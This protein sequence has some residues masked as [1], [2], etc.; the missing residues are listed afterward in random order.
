[1]PIVSVDLGLPFA[2]AA[3]EEIFCVGDVHG[4]AKELDELLDLAASI[5]QVPGRRR[6]IVFNGDL[7]DRGPKSLCA[8]D[9]AISAK[10]RI[11]ADRVLGVMGN[12]CQM[13]K[14]ALIDEEDPVSICAAE[15]WL[16]NGGG[17]VIEE[18][19]D[20]NPGRKFD[21]PAALGP[22]RIA[23]L[24][25]LVSHY[26]SG[27]IMFVHAGLNPLIPLD[28][29]LAADW[30]V[31]FRRT[32]VPRFREANHWAWVRKPFLDHMPAAGEGHHGY[33]VIHGHSKPSAEPASIN[34]QVRRY[35]LNVDGGSYDTGEV[36]MARIVGNQATLF[37]AHP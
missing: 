8:M 13:L 19:L 6:V 14:V 5:S 15:T 37:M 34:E 12:H 2:C 23:W 29:F 22:R 26:V 1:M 36:R 3:D 33:F 4:L 17:T 32:A 10:D 28:E 24:D 7:I 11:G 18:M 25:S 16:G 35:R 31:D 21:V 27:K 20:E 9:L 30:I